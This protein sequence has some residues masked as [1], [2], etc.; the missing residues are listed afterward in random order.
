MIVFSADSYDAR[1]FF[2][3]LVATNHSARGLAVNLVNAAPN[4]APG[5]VN[6][7]T[8]TAD[9]QTQTWYFI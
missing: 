4:A 7:R 9:A 3:S 2:D 8:Q 5:A 1:I 6:L